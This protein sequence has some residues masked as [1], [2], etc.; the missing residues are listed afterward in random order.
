MMSVEFVIKLALSEA[1]SCV[2]FK[3]VISIS[4]NRFINDSFAI[5]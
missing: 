3:N 5:G 1:N 4:I 2:Q